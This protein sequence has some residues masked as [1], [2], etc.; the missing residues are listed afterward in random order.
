[1]QGVRLPDARVLRR[2]AGN[3]RR[4]DRPPL[5]SG[6]LRSPARALR[7]RG[8][9]PE[10]NREADRGAGGREQ[11][12]ERV[13]IS[14]EHARLLE[15]RASHR[16]PEGAAAGHTFP[17]ERSDQKGGEESEE[18]DSLHQGR[19]GEH[20][21]ERR[22]IEGSRGGWSLERRNGRRNRQSGPGDPRSM[23]NPA[24]LRPAALPTHRLARRPVRGAHRARRGKTERGPPGEAHRQDQPEGRRDAQE[25]SHGGKATRDRGRSSP[26][27]GATHWRAFQGPPGS[28]ISS[29]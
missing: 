4:E 2:R 13:E 26:P 24:A 23:R 27:G 5:R 11:D 15:K 17:R 10:R 8:L 9:A 18:A 19:S 14:T 1:G 12:Q 29:K 6:L 20:P 28:Q 22:A 7:R 16:E 25:I 21:A 3:G